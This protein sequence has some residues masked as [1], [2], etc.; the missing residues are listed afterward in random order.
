MVTGLLVRGV[1]LLRGIHGDVDRFGFL[2][3]LVILAEGLVTLSDD[4]DADLPLRDRRHDSPPFLVGTQLVRGAIVFPELIELAIDAADD[5]GGAIY[6]A[7]CLGFHHDADFS[8]VGG[9]EERD[10]ARERTENGSQQDS[11]P[12]DS[13]ISPRAMWSCGVKVCCAGLARTP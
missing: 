3:D 5:H 12:H 7:P 10:E 8:L 6:G 11:I 1:L 4:L 13:I 9:M 2:F